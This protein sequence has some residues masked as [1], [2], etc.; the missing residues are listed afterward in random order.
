LHC[1]RALV[2]VYCKEAGVILHCGRALVVLYCKEAGVILHC[3]RAVVVVYCKE[4][5][6]MLHCG[7]AGPPL[8][9]FPAPPSIIPFS[10]LHLSSLSLLSP[11]SFS[12]MPSF[13]P[14]YCSTHDASA[15]CTP[16]RVSPRRVSPPRVSSPYPSSTPPLTP[17]PRLLSLPLP[18]LPLLDIA[19]ARVSTSLG[20]QA[21]CQTATGPHA[22]PWYRRAAR[23]PLVSQGGMRPPIPMAARRVPPM[24]ECR[25]AAA[26]VRMMG[27]VFIAS[28][29]DGVR[30]H[31][32][33]V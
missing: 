20:R 12:R 3:G 10:L 31:S 19:V 13:S 1:G 25:R 2:V 23:C 27:Y 9:S 4:A 18:L 14:S 22:A 21:R 33:C 16:R 11:P 29:Y 17:P 26:R 6:V 5:G 7:R 30:V 24:L 28:A 8:P 32:E 15:G